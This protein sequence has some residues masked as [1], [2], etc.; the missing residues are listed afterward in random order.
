ML[1]FIELVRF[2]LVM[3]KSLSSNEHTPA[4]YYLTPLILIITYVSGLLTRCIIFNYF[5]TIF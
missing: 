5:S 3:K 1:L 2:I 4:V